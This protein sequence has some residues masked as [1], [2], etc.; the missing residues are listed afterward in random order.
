[1]ADA[2]RVILRSARAA[3][4]SSRARPIWPGLD[5]WGKTE[6]AALET[7]A[8]YVPRYADVAERASM[9]AGLARQAPMSPSWS[10][11]PDPARP[12]SGDRPR[13]VRARTRGHLGRRV[14]ARLRLLE[15]CWAYFDDALARATADLRPGPRGGGWPRDVLERHVYVN[16]PEQMTRKVEVRSPRDMVLDPAGRAIHR[17]QTLDA[18]R[19]YHAAGRSARTWPLA[20]LIRRIAHHLMDHAW[21]LED[22]RDRAAAPGLTTSPEE[23]EHKEARDVPSAR[24][25]PGELASDLA[26][27]AA[28]LV[29]CSS[30][31]RTSAA[32]TTKPS[33]T[34]MTQSAVASALERIIVVAR[35]DGDRGRRKTDPSP[36]TSHRPMARDHPRRC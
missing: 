25:C 10:G 15:A 35:H 6:A 26:L 12:T 36:F 2:M 28:L 1:M 22:R 17:Q 5:R 11:H 29:A 21:E 18:I 23:P 32:P 9:A 24:S 4:G 3:G 27:S 33:A 16:E 7:L 34:A 8:T 13:P 30:G 20:F 31:G 14:G 19:A